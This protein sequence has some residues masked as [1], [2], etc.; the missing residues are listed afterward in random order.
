MK[1]LEKLKELGLELPGV[2]IPG[3]NYASVNIRKDI[4]Y[5]A[6]QFP[7]RN[8]QYFYQGRLGDELTTE[9]GYQA[10][11]LC[12]LNVLAQINKNPGF[13]RLIG[14]NHI[15]IY[16][17]STDSWDDAPKMADVASDLFLN[18]LGDKGQHSRAII[19]VHRLPRNLCAGLTATFTVKNK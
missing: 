19:G 3:G 6:I 11:Q 2:S 14:L 15:D 10:M 18:V 9:E 17:Q 1:P 8:K 7:I 4:A 16:F 13:D 12:A 5:V